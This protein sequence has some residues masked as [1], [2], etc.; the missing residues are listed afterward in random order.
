VTQ[1]DT[2]VEI[3]EIYHLVLFFNSV[4]IIKAITI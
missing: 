3:V 4:V 2:W 1:Y